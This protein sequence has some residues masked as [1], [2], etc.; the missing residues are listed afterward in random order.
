MGGKE[1]I[2]YL[3]TIN[4]QKTLKGQKFGW[5]TGV[6][7]LSPA[8]ESG[9][10]NTCPWASPLCRAWCLKRSGKMRFKEA[11]IARI[12]RT[13]FFHQN[14]KGFGQFL[15]KEIDALIRKTDR[16]GFRPAVRLNGT[17]DIPWEGVF[18]WLFEQFSGVQFYDYTKSIGRIVH[19]CRGRMP[20]NYK[21]L[22]SLSESRE[23]EMEALEALG[24]G[25]NVATVLEKPFP[26][27][28]MGFPVIDGD[29]SDL[30]FLDP[31]P[32]IVALKP[33]GISLA[34]RERAGAFI[35]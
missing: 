23:S 10:I 11:R 15:V 35:R 12:R 24:M 19:Q 27:S 25:F 9:T 33:K 13:R 29:V 3:L 16:E 14:R 34:A 8:D 7:Y 21:L 6:M 26:S 2:V 32:R 20:E 4:S 1:L 17:S 22:F 5:M 31:R 28:Y 18:P 30:R